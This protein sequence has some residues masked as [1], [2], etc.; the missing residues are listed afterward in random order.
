MYPIHF[1]AT[2][3]LVNRQGKRR[4]RRPKNRVSTIYRGRFIPHFFADLSFA[5]ALGSDLICSEPPVNRGI[6]PRERP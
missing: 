3:V 6:N 1:Q 4:N 2:K 5:T